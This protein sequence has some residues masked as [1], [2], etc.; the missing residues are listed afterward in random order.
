MNYS[1]RCFST[2]S[3]GTRACI[4]ASA[5]GDWENGGWDCYKKIEWKMKDIWICLAFQVD[6]LS[7]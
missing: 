1:N 5:L 4:Y 2:Q 7:C 3:S 6:A